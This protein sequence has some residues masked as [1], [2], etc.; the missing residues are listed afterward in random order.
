MI[1]INVQTLIHKVLTRGLIVNVGKLSLGP[2]T[3]TI[4]LGEYNFQ[5]HGHINF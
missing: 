3:I 1:R 4:C 2:P 5:P